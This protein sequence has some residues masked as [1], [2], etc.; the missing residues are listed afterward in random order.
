MRRLALLVLLAAPL[1]AQDPGALDPK[2]IAAENAHVRVL[3]TRY[4]PGEGRAMHEHPARVVVFLTDTKVEVTSED[5]T[6]RVL[7]RKAGDADVAPPTRHAVRNVGEAPFE[8]VEVELKAPTTASPLGDAKAED[9]EHTTVVAETDRVRVLRTRI[10]PGDTAPMHGHGERVTV[11]LS[12]GRM[13][14]TAP[15]GKESVTPMSAG[16]VSIGA[17]T[18]HAAANLGPTLHD[19]ITVELVPAR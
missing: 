12:G 15:D 6:K 2:T 3:K 1:A 5:G 10:A 13:R 19:A 18:R 7:D 17:P 16:D 8:T 14:T 9:P 11:I 4:A